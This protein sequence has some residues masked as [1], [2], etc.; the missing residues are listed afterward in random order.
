MY[1]PYPDGA[2]RLGESIEK[3]AEK[4]LREKLL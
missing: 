4:D 2:R 1:S 3:L